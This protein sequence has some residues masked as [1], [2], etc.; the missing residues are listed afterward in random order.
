MKQ[1]IPFY[2]LELVKFIITQA[3]R[4][5]KPYIQFFPHLTRPDNG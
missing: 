1:I 5:R 3:V 4:K 2:S